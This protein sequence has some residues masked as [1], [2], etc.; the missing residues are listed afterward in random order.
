MKPNRSVYVIG[1][2]HSTF[3]GRGRSEFIWR[4]HP[5]Y[6]KKSNPNLEQHLATAV[7]KV[8]ALTNLDPTRIDKA[9]VSNFLAERFC[10]QGHLGA[11]LPAVC[12]ALNGKPISRVEAA[13]ASGGAAIISGIDALQGGCDF[14]LVAGVEIETNVPGKEGVEHMALAAHFAKQRHLEFALFPYIFAKRAKAYK[15][16]FGVTDSDIA[17]VVEKA[18]RNANKNPLA[19]KY[20]V[21]LTLQEATQESHHNPTFLQNPE[22][23]PHI[24]MSDCTAFTDGA[25][26]LILASEDGLRKAGIAKSSTIEILSYGHR[27]CAL[28]ED[29]DPTQLHNMRGAAEDAYKDG[30]ISPEQIQ[31]AEVHDCFSI[32]EIQMV[33]AMGFAAIGTG[34]SWIAHGNSQLQGRLPINTGGGLLGFG[35]PIGATGIKQVGEIWRQMKGHC[36]KYQVNSPLQY[37]LTANL[38]GDDRT[39]IVMLMQNH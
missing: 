28:G 36:H 3:L 32:T 10:N 12:P 20:E 27:V 23:K 30:R 35:H 4:K 26:A 31:I 15:E 21:Q 33:E 9:F 17:H 7:R 38:G 13:C 18:Y 8:F 29:T 1:A 5:D 11:M 14:A 22:L 16:T 39:G 24:K 6:G 19:L 37:G 25:S 34:A 2:A